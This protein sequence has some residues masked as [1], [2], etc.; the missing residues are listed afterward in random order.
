MRIAHARYFLKY[1]GLLCARHRRRSRVFCLLFATAAAGFL[2]P[3]HLL[4]PARGRSP[5]NS[6]PNSPPTTMCNKNKFC[7]ICGFIVTLTSK[8]SRKRQTSYNRFKAAWIEKAYVAYFDVKWDPE[9]KEGMG[10]HWAPDVLCERCY[11]ALYHWWFHVK[12]IRFFLKA[13]SWRKPIN[14]EEECFFCKSNTTGLTH[15][16]RNKIEHYHFSPATR[17]VRGKEVEYDT[18]ASKAVPMSPDMATR[19]FPD[20][21]DKRPPS[22]EQTVDEDDETKEEEE[23][24][25]SSFDKEDYIPPYDIS[26]DAM[27]FNQV[28]VI[29]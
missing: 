20:Q 13:V 11:M 18:S 8:G 2:A 9:I 7:Y 1:P 3:F 23:E 27:P 21:S 5:P 22:T 6:P 10:P 14:H 19:P 16:T 15:K 26:S 17:I 29:N 25:E 4:C 12:P 28:C 24:E